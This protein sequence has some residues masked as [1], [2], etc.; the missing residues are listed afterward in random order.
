MPHHKT[1]AD[2]WAS[3][4]T[5]ANLKQN[6]LFAQTIKAVDIPVAAEV[7]HPASGL[8]LPPLGAALAVSL[9]SAR[10]VLNAPRL[11]SRS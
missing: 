9:S 8:L 2:G 5:V 1:A 6:M 3:A 10:V 7:L 4:A 11:R